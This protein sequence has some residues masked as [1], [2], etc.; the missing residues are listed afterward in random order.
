L[1]LGFLSLLVAGIQQFGQLWDANMW[2]V[3]QGRA[4]LLVVNCLAIAAEEVQQ[5][6]A[7][8]YVVPNID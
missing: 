8:R 2:N 1:G 7:D 5:T 6:L 3:L 4:L